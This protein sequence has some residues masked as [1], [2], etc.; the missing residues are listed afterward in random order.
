[1]VARQA[2]LSM[3]I[4]HVRMLEWVAISFSRGSSWPRDRTCVSCTAGRFFTTWATREA[5]GD[6]L[7]HLLRFMYVSTAD[8]YLEVSYQSEGWLYTFQVPF[9]EYRWS[10]IITVTMFFFFFIIYDFQ[11]YSESN[12]SMKP[13]DTLGN[14]NPQLTW[15]KLMFTLPAFPNP[16]LHPTLFPKVLVHFPGG[17]PILTLVCRG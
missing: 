5:L 6:V 1:M 13:Q 12:S 4:L 2:P 11:V 8:P 14:M 10:F 15:W 7:S 16:P 9:R 3:G 17:N